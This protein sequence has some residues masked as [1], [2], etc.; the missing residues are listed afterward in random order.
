VVDRRLALLG[1]LES[2]R[3]SLVRLKSGLGTPDIVEGELAEADR[4]LGG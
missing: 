1:A 4:L 3:L 2:I